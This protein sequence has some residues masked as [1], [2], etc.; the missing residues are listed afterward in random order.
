LDDVLAAAE[1]PSLDDLPPEQLATLRDSL[2]SFFA[3][4]G[5]LLNDPE[6]ASGWGYTDGTILEGQGRSSM[7]VPSMFAQ[8]AGIDQVESLLDIGT[9]V[10]LLAVAAARMWPSCHVVGIDTWEPSLERA[11]A[12]VAGAGLDD[13]IE[14]RDQNLVDLDDVDRFDVAWL[15][16]FFVDADTLRVGLPRVLAAMRPGGRII[17]GRFEP[18][19]DPLAQATLRLRTVRDGGSILTEDEVVELVRDAGFEDVA[20]LPKAGPVMLG[21][22]SGRKS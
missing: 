2:R 21:F 8:A 18:R 6:R 4:S 7:F 10:G 9:G 22:I 14:I 15:P 20:P 19:A 17:V 16:S 3:Q 11:R 12:N 13:R 1:I 5:D